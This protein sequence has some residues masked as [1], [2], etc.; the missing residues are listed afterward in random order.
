M[1]VSTTKDESSLMISLFSY[2][3]DWKLWVDLDEQEVNAAGPGLVYF[4][5]ND[6]K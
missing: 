4:I 1:I 3:T 5:E 6:F 2:W